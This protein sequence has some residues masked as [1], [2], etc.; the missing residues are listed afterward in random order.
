[1]RS[2]FFTAFAIALAISSVQQIPDSF[3]SRLTKK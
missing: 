1:M 3:F 2:C